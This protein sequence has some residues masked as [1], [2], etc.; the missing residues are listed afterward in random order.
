MHA[1]SLPAVRWLAGLSLAA[2]IVAMNGCA[3][4]G[5]APL[6]FSGGHEIGPDDYGRPVVL[7]AAALGVKPDEFRRAFS[8]VAP[9]RG[10]PP[11][12]GQARRNKEALMSV[13]APL[14]VTNERLDEVSDCYRYQPQRGGLWRTTDA[15]GATR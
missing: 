13:L 10:G 3:P 7:I 11:T 14:G 8:G 2:A 15:T 1:R 5:S 9:A 4:A 6:V 12:G